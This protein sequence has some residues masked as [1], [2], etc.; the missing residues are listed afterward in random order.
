MFTEQEWRAVVYRGVALDTVDRN[1]REHDKLGLFAEQGGGGGRIG[2]HPEKKAHAAKV[3]HGSPVSDLKS[4]D[5]PRGYL[6]SNYPRASGE[7]EL[8]AATKKI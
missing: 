3:L 6:V 7:L 8:T 5:A 1:G 4:S 2:V